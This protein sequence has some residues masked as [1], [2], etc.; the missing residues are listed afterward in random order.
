M[1]T[2]EKKV[3]NLDDAMK[4]KRDSIDQMQK[5]KQSSME[6]LALQRD[7]TLLTQAQAMSGKT[8]EEMKKD[9]DNWHAWLE[10]KMTNQQL[11]F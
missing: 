4:F 5:R 1:A 6:Q 11:N 8:Q 2:Y 7:A 9:W 10:G 3:H